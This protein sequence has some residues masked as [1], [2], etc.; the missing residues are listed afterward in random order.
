MLDGINNG[1]FVDY[2][3]GTTSTFNAPPP[4]PGGSGTFSSG[5]TLSTT[6]PGNPANPA[7]E[8]ADKKAAFF[9]RMTNSIGNAFGKIADAMG[10]GTLSRYAKESFASFDAD[11]NKGIDANEF[12]AVSAIVGK[13][14][15]EVDRNT[16]QKVTF[17]EF[18]SVVSQIVDNNF[19]TADSNGDG[20]LNYNEASASGNVVQLG[21]NNSFI[22][23]D[24]NQDQLLS[25]NEFIALASDPRFV[26]KF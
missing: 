8:N 1:S 6:F 3:A 21:S 14:F 9:Q 18:K 12:S 24:K 11:K 13:S 26:R 20:F 7:I 2:S 19:K 23:H 16:D 15:Q 25:K 17:S 5:D 4:P 22:D 10:L